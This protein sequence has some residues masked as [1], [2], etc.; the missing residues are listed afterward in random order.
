MIALL[1]EVSCFDSFHVAFR[2]LWF[3]DSLYETIPEIYELEEGVCLFPARGNL[4]ETWNDA[5]MK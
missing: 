4:L 2:F 3:H 1:N 5:D